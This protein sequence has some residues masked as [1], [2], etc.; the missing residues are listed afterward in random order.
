MPDDALSEHKLDQVQLFCDLLFALLDYQPLLLVEIEKVAALGS[1]LVPSIIIIITK[2]ISII[3][4]LSTV[5]LLS[6]DKGEKRV[7]DVC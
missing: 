1:E 3:K 6:L 7:D 5:L 4:I 2:L